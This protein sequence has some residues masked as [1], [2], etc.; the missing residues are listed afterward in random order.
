VAKRDYYEVL[1]ISKSA[2]ADEV[3]RAYRKLAMKHHPD[4]HGGDDA[5][6]KEVNEAYEVLKDD[7]KRSQYDQFGHNGPFGAGQQGGGA[8]GFNGA[9][10]DFSQFQNAGGFGDI[11][12]MFFQQGGGG[13][14]QSRAEARGEDLEVGVTLDFNEAIFGTE[15]TLKF[16][17]AERCD[18][19]DGDGAEPG[20]KI[21]TCDTCKGQGQIN[22]V[23]QTILG[24]M[25]QTV[26][27]PTCK[28]KGKIPE[29]KC[30]KCHGAGTTKE[31]R[32][33]TVKIPGGID[34]GSTI[35]LNGK[36]G[37]HAT[38]PNGDL[39]VQVRVRPHAKLHRNGQNIESMVSIPMVVAALG[40]EVPVET[41]DGKVILKVPA[42][43]QSSK[44]FK[45]S[46]HGVPSIQ[47]RKRGDHLVT[48]V[49]EVPTK[50]NPKQ[51]E[52]L[53]EFD[54]VSEKKPFWQK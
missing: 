49:V 26:V 27:C 5:Q 28:G 30:S 3:K 12:D 44:L 2:T 35:R 18:R 24:A 11:F 16:N 29:Q 6:F 41:V 10:F 13:G 46:E 51:K 53:K 4:K 14:R 48:V 34:N 31:A 9:N 54:A 38:G 19:C 45:L 7:Q 25:R 20:T 1:G 39:Y 21:K 8:Q 42:G 15:R 17:A 40:G 33:I 36:G 47:G 22:R 52:L 50:L 32:D 23:Q 37:A 43:T